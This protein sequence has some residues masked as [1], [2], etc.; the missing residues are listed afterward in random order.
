MNP[1]RLISIATQLALSSDDTPERQ[2]D[3]RRAVST[4]YYAMFHTLANSNANTLIG[5]LINN[6][7]GLYASYHGPRTTDWSQSRPTSWRTAA[8]SPAS[9]SG[10]THSASWLS[11][12][13]SPKPSSSLS[14][15]W[16]AAGQRHRSQRSHGPTPAHSQASAP[17]RRTEEPTRPV[18]NPHT[19]T[20]G[21]PSKPQPAQA[22]HPANRSNSIEDTPPRTGT[23]VRS[24][25]QR[26]GA[27]AFR[28]S[29]GCNPREDGPP[30]FQGSVPRPATRRR[31]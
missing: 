23:A 4:A 6:Q 7:E 15:S 24:P 21:F 30:N 18:G 29:A 22:C 9:P 2:D 20:T 27:L 11:M 10:P 3:L 31:R 5:A 19:L 28:P 12:R 13:T 26:T 17:T 16:P 14:G 25:E 8:T 1:A